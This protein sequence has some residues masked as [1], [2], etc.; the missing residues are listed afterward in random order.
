MIELPRMISVDDHVL[1][2]P[3]L[4]TDRLP[5][6]LR[7]RGPRVERLKGRFAGFARGGFLAVEPD[8]DGQWVDQWVYEDKRMV[9]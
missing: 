3:D 9:R 7:D 6:R 1:E 4:W 5:S 2:A 8:E